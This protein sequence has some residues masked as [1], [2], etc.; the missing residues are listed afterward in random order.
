MTSETG[1]G[2]RRLTIRVAVP[3]L[4]VAGRAVEVRP[5]ADDRDIL[6]GAFDKG[7]GEDPRYLL[8][9]QGPLE[10]AELPH[11]VRL[12]SAQ[13]AEEC[14]GA[15][16]VTVRCE[17]GQVVWDRWRDPDRDGLVLPEIRFEAGQYRAELARATADRGWEWPARTVARLLEEHLTDH[18]DWLTRWEC[19]LHSVSAWPPEPDRFHVLFTFRPGR[20][21]TGTDRPWLQFRITLP[22][23]GEDPAIQARAHA[24]RLL[25]PDDPRAVAELC[26]GSRESA[27]QFGYSWPPRPP[28]RPRR[29]RKGD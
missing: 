7:P 6:A 24:E 16:Y 4:G 27:R 20:A 12:A 14:C 23:S 3:E 9:P 26:G 1:A 18:P 2:P 15:L 10:A 5:L 25:L 29:L 17:G 21:E 11:E 19:E 13:C 8:I 28:R 22:V